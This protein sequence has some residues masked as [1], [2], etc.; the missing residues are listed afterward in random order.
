MRAPHCLQ[1]AVL[2]VGVL[3]LRTVVRMQHSPKLGHTAV[4]SAEYAAATS[5]W[6]LALVWLRR[7]AARRVDMG[8][9]SLVHCVAVLTGIHQCL[10]GNERWTVYQ[11]R[12]KLNALTP[13]AWRWCPRGAR[14]SRCGGR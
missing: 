4:L 13:Q 12:P 14:P 5:G 6:R 8:H 9:H 2:Q 10:T 7:T 3:G 11:D 1:L